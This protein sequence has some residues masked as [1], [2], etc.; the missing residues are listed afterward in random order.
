MELNP[1][2]NREIISAAP[3]PVL[4]LEAALRA[5]T[6]AAGAVC[7]SSGGAA[8]WSALVLLEIS[9]GDKV[10]MAAN[11]HPATAAAVCRAGAL[12]V[13]CDLPPDG[14]HITAETLSPLITTR[15][16]AV[17]TED[18]AGICCDYRAI[19][20][21]LWQKHRLFSP[22]NPMQ[23]II[24]RVAIIA[25]AA[26]ALGAKR[27][28]LMCGAVADFTCFSFGPGKSLSDAA[29]G[30]LCW[31][32][33]VG[34]DHD[35]IDRRLRQPYTHTPDKATALLPQL[36][37]YHELLTRRRAACDQ[38]D[39]MLS[40]LPVELTGHM[41]KGDNIS[42]CGLYPIYLPGCT[43]AERDALI[44]RLKD[45]GITAKAPR[46]PL[47][48]LKAY[49]Q[50]GY[51]IGSF[52]NTYRR[53]TSGLYLPLCAHTSETEAA[54]MAARFIS[55]C[56]ALG[57]PPDRYE[58]LPGPASFLEEGGDLNPLSPQIL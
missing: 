2:P 16:R 49:R 4:R 12:P 9:P 56:V 58:P 14:C 36:D 42:A 20:T 21:M 43:K 46:R 19:K 47:P 32:D 57:L 53:Y 52:P 6:G 24:G 45:E 37:G 55:A 35:Y 26:H 39:G 28:G 3:D 17:I 11:T 10:I 44:A 7:L 31:R 13:L 38:Y 30:A 25:D 48:M 23:E 50:M 5:Y 1:K 34:A 8:A 54:G 18:F 40:Q 41:L 15:T 22:Q 29:G 33:I 51:N 27:E